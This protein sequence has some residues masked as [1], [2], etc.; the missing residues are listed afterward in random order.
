MI[1]EVTI[2][3][4]AKKAGVSVATVSLIQNGKY[5]HL[6]VATIQKVEYY[7]EQMHY[8]PS[9]RA[10]SLVTKK[11]KTI[12]LLIPDLANEYFTQ[13]AKRVSAILADKGYALLVASSEDSFFK[14]N[15]ALDMFATHGIDSLI[16]VPATESFL[17]K[18]LSSFKKRLASFPFPVVVIDREIPS[19]SYPTILSDDYYGGGLAARCFLEQAL[20]RLACLTGPSEVPSS[21][22][23]L[24]GFLDALHQQG[25]SVP[26]ALIMEGDYRPDSGYEKVS[27]LLKNKPLPQGIF[28]FNDAMAYG[29]Y[30]ACQENKVAIGQDLAL[31]GYDDLSFS[32]LLFPALTSI[33]PDIGL[34][35]QEACRLIFAPKPT[36]VLLKIKG[37]LCFRSSVKNG[38]PL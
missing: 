31:I 38:R 11:T 14:E 18:N 22:N 10:A 13:I 5:A 9:T 37:D 27:A 30:R 16:I 26:P 25:V 17:A 28:I 32:S 8:V 15:A 33:R 35:C 7:I 12:G 1:G 3:D 34:I 4:I 29:A 23:R 20:T 36:S 19:S 2:K 24:Q 6:S 21:Q